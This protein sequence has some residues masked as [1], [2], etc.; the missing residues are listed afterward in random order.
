LR[1]LLGRIDAVHLEHV[2]GDI[3][4]DRCNLRGRLPDVI[5]YND[6][7]MGTRC[8]ERVPATTS[9]LEPF[10]GLQAIRSVADIGTMR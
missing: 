8:W 9:K 4:T 1:H 5:R 10:S 7:P 3:Q 2:L 6:L